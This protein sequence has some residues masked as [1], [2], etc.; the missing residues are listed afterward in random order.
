MSIAV[1]LVDDEETF[2]DLV[3]RKLRR[4]GFEVHACGHGN[5][6]LDGCPSLLKYGDDAL[7]QLGG[8][9]G[10]CRCFD[11]EV[12]IEVAAHNRALLLVSQLRHRWLL[13]LT[14]VSRGFRLLRRARSS[15]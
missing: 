2:R 13:N 5:Q 6:A 7:D 3:E 10:A 1:L 4:E 11:H 8:L 12:R 15:S 14:S 9:S